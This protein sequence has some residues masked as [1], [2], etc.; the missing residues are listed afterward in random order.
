MGSQATQRI[1]VGKTVVSVATFIAC[2]S[3]EQPTQLYRAG[4]GSRGIDRV[5]ACPP[6]GTPGGGNSGVAVAKGHCCSRWKSERQCLQV[7]LALALPVEH[8]L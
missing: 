4:L 3:I 8:S 6:P 1:D 2:G 5:T 7:W